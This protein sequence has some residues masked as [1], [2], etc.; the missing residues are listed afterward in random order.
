MMLGESHDIPIRH[1][2][3]IDELAGASSKISEYHLFDSQ[4]V[5]LD[6]SSDFW[7]EQVHCRVRHSTK[8][9]I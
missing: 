4:F 1:L 5:Y 3:G 7:N 8:D 9:P 6:V 2:G